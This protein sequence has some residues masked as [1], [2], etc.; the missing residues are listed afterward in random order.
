MDAAELE[1]NLSLFDDWAERYQYIIDLGK[2]LAPLPDDAR[3]EANKVR[4]CMSQV[5]LIHAVEPGSDGARIT[6]LGDSDSAI[7]RGLI[8]LLFALYSGQTARTILDT[9]LEG[10]FERIGLAQHLSPNRRNGFFSM[11]ES[12]RR[13]ATDVAA[14]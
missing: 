8:A 1:E 10:F 6:F 3:I 13:R 7:V 14:A 9:D 4:G 5:W 12:I 11:V 2:K